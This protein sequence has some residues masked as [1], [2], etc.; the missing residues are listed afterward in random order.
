MSRLVNIGTAVIDADRVYKVEEA[1]G[2]QAEDGG[3]I[4]I[5]YMDTGDAVRFHEKY[6]STVV[7][8][9]FV[10]MIMPAA[11]YRLRFVG[12]EDKN[13][14]AIDVPVAGLA[15]TASGDIRPIVF[16]KGC[17]DALF[18]DDIEDWELTDVYHKD[19]PQKK[20]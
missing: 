3:K 6:Y 7:G 14:V 11:S 17:T 4:L 8:C 12:K 9:D 15:V 18:A 10:K 1:R 2:T 19:G 20:G 16:A 5:A 13:Q